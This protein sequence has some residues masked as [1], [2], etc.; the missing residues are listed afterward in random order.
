MV[1]ITRP[2]REVWGILSHTGGKPRRFRLSNQ[3]TDDNGQGRGKEKKPERKGEEKNRQHR[4]RATKASKAP[5][6]LL[7]LL[8]KRDKEQEREGDGG[9]QR[10]GKAAKRLPKG[11]YRHRVA[12]NL[13]Q[14]PRVWNKS[15]K[16]LF[17]TFF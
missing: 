8:I 6:P 5:H 4:R 14:V 17:T 11:C 13:L 10:Q 15:E 16:P 12:E 2:I 9:D 1:F 3:N 7:G